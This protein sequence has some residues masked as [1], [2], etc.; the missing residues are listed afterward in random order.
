MT[1][2]I[3]DSILLKDKKFS[4]VGINGNELFNPVDFNLHPFSSMT[5]CWRGYVCEYKVSDNKLLLNT[6]QINL[7][8]R[9]PVINGVESLFSNATFN[10]IYTD[11][12]MPIDFTGEILAADKFI[13]KLYVH[14]GFHPA[15]KYET[16]YELVISHGSV[17]NTKDVSEQ[18]ARLR[19]QMHHQ[20]LDSSKK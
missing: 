6:L 20:L 5:S 7:H 19:E 4:I 11:L 18:M 8:Q 10:N 9:G 12:H 3:H 13:R 16:V 1:A 15:W 17:L 14:M 2:Q